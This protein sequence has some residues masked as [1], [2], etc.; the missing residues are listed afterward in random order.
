MYKEFI[1]P[2]A[3]VLTPN[4]FELELLSDKKIDNEDDAWNAI[5]MMHDRG[6]PSVVLTSLD[7]GDGFIH[8]LGSQV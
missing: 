5:Y 4:Q 3:D 6:V 8:T 2:L 7:I 1:I